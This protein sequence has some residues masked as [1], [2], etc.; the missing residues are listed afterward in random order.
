MTTNQRNTRN[1]C[2]SRTTINLRPHP[3]PVSSR[4]DRIIDTLRPLSYA[5][6]N[7][8]LD[9]LHVQVFPEGRRIVLSLL[10]SAGTATFMMPAVLAHEVGDGLKWL[11]AQQE[12]TPADPPER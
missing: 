9:V 7:P 2:S 6:G 1:E 11:A 4:S 8:D 10:T 5:A 3:R 12:T